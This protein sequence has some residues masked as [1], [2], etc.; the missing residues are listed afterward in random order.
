[1]QCLGFHQQPWVKLG[2]TQRFRLCFLS[3]MKCEK[4]WCG[5]PRHV[6][7][8]AVQNELE[9]LVARPEVLFL[10]AELCIALDTEL[11]IICTAV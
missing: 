2:R 6:Q 10:F 1:M 11:P 4:S 9:G 3:K 5:Q 7:E 8:D